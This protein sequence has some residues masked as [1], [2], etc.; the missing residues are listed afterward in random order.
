MSRRTT[1]HD[2]C[3]LIAC[4]DC[5][6]D[7]MSLGELARQAKVHPATVRRRLRRAGIRKLLGRW[8]YP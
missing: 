8:R 5:L 2:I 1:F 7:G 4:V 3:W 6:N